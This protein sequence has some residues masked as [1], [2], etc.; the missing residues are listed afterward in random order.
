M[1]IL[2]NG[3]KGPVPLTAKEA[4]KEEEQKKERAR[5]RRALLAKKAR[6]QR[7]NRNS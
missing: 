7:L 5:K 2:R 3:P 1:A 4:E 6:Q